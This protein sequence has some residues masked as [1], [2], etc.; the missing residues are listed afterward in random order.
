MRQ[1]YRSATLTT[2]WWSFTALPE[3]SR[4]RVTAPG[5]HASAEPASWPAAGL[6]VAYPIP[7]GR[8]RQ[9]VAV[10]RQAELAA[11]LRER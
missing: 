8:D 1:G 9:Q 5:R 2:Q 3:S 11:M 4:R 6:P 7:V 10:Q